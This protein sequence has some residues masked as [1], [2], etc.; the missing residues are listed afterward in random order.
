MDF[1]DVSGS[2][3]PVGCCMTVLE[4]SLSWSF[5][6]K[7]KMQVLNT[8]GLFRPLFLNQLALIYH[9]VYKEKNIINI[10]CLFLENGTLSP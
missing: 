8:R 1:P 10:S 6:K 5:F 7:E 4:F 9:F 3:G 2:R